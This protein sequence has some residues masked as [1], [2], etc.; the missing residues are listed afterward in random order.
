MSAA[1]STAADVMT[2][3]DATAVSVARY[4]V[5]SVSA[6]VVEDDGQAAVG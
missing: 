5:R 2:V 3:I 1:V 6:Q 4:V